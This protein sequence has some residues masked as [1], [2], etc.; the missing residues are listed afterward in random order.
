MTERPNG[1]ILHL[2]PDEDEITLNR[3]SLIDNL[4][5]LHQ[6]RRIFRGFRPGESYR[7]SF[8]NERLD[9][10]R[11]DGGASDSVRGM[12]AISVRQ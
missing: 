5:P 6:R 3:N 8:A 9:L 12:I 7:L 11:H 2:R 10:R 1:A 4:G